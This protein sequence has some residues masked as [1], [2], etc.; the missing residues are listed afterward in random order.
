M[1]TKRSDF[2]PRLLSGTLRSV[3]TPTR[4]PKP[5]KFL[6][7]TPRHRKP[8]RP[9]NN[10]PPI[11]CDI[12]RLNPACWQRPVRLESGELLVHCDSADCDRAYFKLVLKVKHPLNQKGFL[13]AH[14]Q[15]AHKRR[16]QPHTSHTNKKRPKGSKA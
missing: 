12:C 10:P 11:L 6:G 8:G 3:T 7:A 2:T 15:A 9:L 13:S 5:P 4:H 16:E 1:T 14:S